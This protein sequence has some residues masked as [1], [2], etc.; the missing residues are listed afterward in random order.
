MR[1]LII[2]KLRHYRVLMSVLV[3]LSFVSNYAQAQTDVSLTHSY[4]GLY[5]YVTT[6][7][8]LRSSSNYLN[9]CSVNPTSTATLSGIPSTATVF[10]AYLY[11]ANSGSYRDTSVTLNNQTINAARSFRD[12][13]NGY[14]YFSGGYQDVT[15]LVAATGNGTYTFKDLYINTG[16][17]YNNRYC[18]TSSVLGGWALV[19]IYEDPNEIPKRVNVYDGF[20][21]SKDS[22]QSF[23]LTSLIVPPV[24]EAK[25]SV[26]AW[27]GDPDLGGTNETLRVNG[28]RLSDTLN[29]SLNIFNSTIN[30]LNTNSSYGV[31]LDTF[32]VTSLISPGDTSVLTQ[33]NAGPDL[34]ILNAVVLAVSTGN[35]DLELSKRV[36]NP[37]PN[38]G[39]T[40]TF[41]VELFNRGPDPAAN[42]E[43]EDVLPAGLTLVSATPGVGTYTRNGMWMID[44]IAPN[45]THT[46][47]VTASVNAGTLNSTITNVAEIMYVG[48]Q[49]DNDS[50]PGNGVTSEDDYAQASITV[51][52]PNEADLEIQKIVNIDGPEV[53]EMITYTITVENNGPV[54]AINTVVN[55]VLPANL[56]L[57]QTSGCQEDITAVPTCTLGTITAG[58]SK[59]YTIEAQVLDTT[60]GTVI[61]NTASVKSETSDPNTS[62]NTSH[63][64]ITVSGLE[65]FKSVC[66]LSRSACS[67]DADF[68]A[69]VEGQPGDILEYRIVFERFGIAA[70]DVTLVDDLPLN[71][72]FLA[73]Q[74]G[75]TG[76]VRFVCPASSQDLDFAVTSDTYRFS[77]NNKAS[78][79][80]VTVEL[81][82]TGADGL[83]RGGIC[84]V[85]QLN[86]GDEGMFIFRVTID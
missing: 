51:S 60:L 64:D 38:E 20:R 42:I 5:N 62:N 39:D 82:V 46:L 78:S 10:K 26:L 70:F 8:T 49:F 4:K 25:V 27:E 12:V 50:E 65:L 34:V 66:N 48:D 13:Y 16:S 79:N 67:A 3:L 55:D 19:V 81:D 22:S 84:N 44:Y 18:S 75:A 52:E 15:S 40:V 85:S 58:S 11:W 56:L 37:E 61:T 32:D 68:K 63:A 6:G 45:Q 77:S 31:D 36:D 28:T 1:Q 30:T 21:L 9:A 80:G 86:A 83:T 59:S 57:I 72:S 73:N 29:P 14:Y 71:T 2:N 23:N 7:G 69:S 74:Y 43:I 53:N 33:V 41:T 35:A 17:S 24:P 54:D 76:D 47:T